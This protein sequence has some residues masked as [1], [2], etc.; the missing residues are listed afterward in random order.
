MQQLNPYGGK[1]EGETGAASSKD[2]ANPDTRARLRRAARRAFVLNRFKFLFSPRHFACKI[3]VQRLQQKVAHRKYILTRLLL[4]YNPLC[5][6]FI[7]RLQQRVVERKRHAAERSRVQELLKTTPRKLNYDVGYDETTGVFSFR[8]ELGV[9]TYDEHP[10][11]TNGTVPSYD[12]DGTVVP[13]LQPPV[14][15]SVGVTP[16]NG[17]RL[18]NY[19]V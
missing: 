13:P 2:K 3:F 17:R 12:R 6:I 10:A 4:F 18:P 19:R 11:G 1:E 16:G 9:I 14:L 8:S 5:E 15:P 7:R